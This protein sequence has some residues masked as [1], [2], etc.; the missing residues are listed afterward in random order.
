M[1]VPNRRPAAAPSAVPDGVAEEGKAE[2]FV[3]L[4]EQAALFFGSDRR[5]PTE[6]RPVVRVRKDGL[7]RVVLP[8]TT[9]DHSESPEFFALTRERAMWTRPNDDRQS[10]AHYRCEVVSDDAL[11]AKIGV[12]NQN[13]RVDLL[14]WL[15]SRY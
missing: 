11:R 10:Y 12:M 5:Q 1:F 7:R 4:C 9:R 3:Q 15:L 6:Y 13:A 14:R 8:C 2:G